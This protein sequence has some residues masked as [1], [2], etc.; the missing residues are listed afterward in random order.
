MF[1]TISKIL[2]SSCFVLGS[3]AYS[4]SQGCTV[5]FPGGGSY[6]VCEETKNDQGLIR[7]DYGGGNCA[8]AQQD[9]EN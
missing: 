4:S 3:F 1:K 8:P 6:E 2:L 7:C 9:V 5:F